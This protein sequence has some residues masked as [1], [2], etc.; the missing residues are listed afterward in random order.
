MREEYYFEFD[1]F[2]GR[3][4]IYSVALGHRAILA[5]CDAPDVAQKIVDALN[6]MVRK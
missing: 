3:C 4:T 1:H 5:W 6:K 2:N